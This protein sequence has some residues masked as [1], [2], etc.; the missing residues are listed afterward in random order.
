MSQGQQFGPLQPV[1]GKFVRVFVRFSLCSS[2][3]CESQTTRAVITAE[4]MQSTWQQAGSVETA[5]QVLPGKMLLHHCLHDVPVHCLA[6][7]SPG[8]QG[9]TGIAM[10]MC[11]H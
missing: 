4:A 10:P 8:G 6:A 1:C 9:A 7:A 5:C 11:M 3:D 2:S